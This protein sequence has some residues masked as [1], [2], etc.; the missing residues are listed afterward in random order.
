MRN[1]PKSLYTKATAS[2]QSKMPWASL[3][4]LV[5][6]GRGL[7]YLEL[8][9][10]LGLFLALPLDLAG[11]LALLVRLHSCLQHALS[12]LR[13][14]LFCDL[15]HFLFHEVPIIL[16]SSPLI[17]NLACAWRSGV[18]IFQSFISCFDAVELLTA[19]W[20][21]RWLPANKRPR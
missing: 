9:R 19:L 10:A 13:R 7:M 12:G 14:A 5:S 20:V 21:L 18:F 2:A 16:C 15:L 8:H 17:G 1:S 4:S 6:F 3:T 11:V